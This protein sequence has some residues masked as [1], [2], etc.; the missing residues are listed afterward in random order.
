MVKYAAKIYNIEKMDQISF[1]NI[2]LTIGDCLFLETLLLEM[3]ATTIQY[4]TRLK[5]EQTNEEQK[6]IGEIEQLEL[7]ENGN[8]TALTEKK[9]NWNFSAIKNLT[10]Y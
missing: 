1:E 3:R 10:E 6:L 5:K 4:L 7:Q 2:H 8:L 9:R